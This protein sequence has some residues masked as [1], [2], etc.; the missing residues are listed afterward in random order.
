MNVI[1]FEFEDPRL[2]GIIN[3]EGQVW[4]DTKLDLA[5]IVTGALVVKVPNNVG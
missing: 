1:E 2:V 4:R 3:N 5:T